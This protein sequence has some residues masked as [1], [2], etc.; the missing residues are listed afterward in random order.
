M[1]YVNI[2]VTLKQDIG[3]L[4]AGTKLWLGGFIKGA[5]GRLIKA[6]DEQNQAYVL[7]IETKKRVMF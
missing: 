6:Y 2:W 4:K 3:D 7:D 5:K 1:K